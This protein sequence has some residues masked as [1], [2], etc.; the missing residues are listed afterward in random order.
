MKVSV[1]IPYFGNRRQQLKCSLPFLMNQTYPDY[2]VILVDDGARSGLP[3]L[4]KSIRYFKIR[5]DNSPARSSNTAIRYGVAKCSGD[6]IIMG[7]PELLVPYDAVERM[8]SLSDIKRRNV[9]I[10]YH[11]NIKQAHYLSIS[12]DWM[13]DF[14]K[15][16]NVSSFWGTQ[17]PWGYTNMETHRHRN[18]FSWSGSTRERFEEYMIPDTEEWGAEDVYVHVKELENGEPCLPIDIEVYHQEHER[19]Y[20]T[21]VEYS[22]RRQRIRNSMFD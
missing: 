7:Q 20:G 18:H 14:E 1:V 13:H 2:E 12:N 10:Q 6:F 22:V 19:V 9:A 4:D 15:I 3:E 8:V 21:I 17:T 16:K 5:A 11:L